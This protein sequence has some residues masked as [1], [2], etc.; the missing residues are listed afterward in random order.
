M[1]P[2]LF[3][4]GALLATGL[5]RGDIAPTTFTGSDIL[6]LQNAEVR[7]A[8]ASVRI[9][10]GEP[11]CALEASFAMINEREGLTELEVGFPVGAYHPDPTGRALDEDEESAKPLLEPVGQ[12]VISI[13]VNGAPVTAYRRLPREQINETRRHYTAWYFAKIAFRPG[14]SVITVNTRLSPSPAEAPYTVNLSYCVSTGG[15]WLGPIGWETVE[16]VFPG[17]SAAS[18]IAG[19]VPRGGKIAGDTVRWE[20]QAFEPQGPEY[21]IDLTFYHPTVAAKLAAMRSAHEQKPEDS[22]AALR[23]ATHLFN[24]GAAKGNSGFPP[25]ELSSDMFQKMLTR[26]ESP[27]DRAL[28]T[29]FYRKSGDHFAS[30]SSEWTEDRRQLVRILADAGYCA[31]YAGLRHVLEARRLV[32]Q[33]LTRNPRDAAAWNVYLTHFWR[34]SFAARGHWFGTTVFSQPLRAAIESAYKQCPK[35]PSIRSWHKAMK[36]DGNPPTITPERPDIV[37][38]AFRNEFGLP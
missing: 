37:A 1:K 7:M 10:W 14:A 34:F 6:P 2:L 15:R 29:R 13:A 9:T 3:L 20:F 8:S 32:E 22:P 23:Y 21:D 38:A 27:A 19:P 12:E 26:I 25:S 16:I 24:L 36:S 4:L 17:A 28:F 5:I 31:D 18:L 30:E 11:N 33:C 35:D